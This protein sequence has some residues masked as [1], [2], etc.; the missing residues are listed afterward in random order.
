M[1]LDTSYYIM[2]T[3]NYLITLPYLRALVYVQ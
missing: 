2:Q 1:A 3:E